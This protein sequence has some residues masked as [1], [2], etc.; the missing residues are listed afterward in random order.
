M[1]GVTLRDTMVHIMTFCD[2]GIWGVLLVE[3]ECWNH[4]GDTK[5]K[6]SVIIKES[7]L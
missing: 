3:I 5:L 7:L 2:G 1:Y 4:E 6:S